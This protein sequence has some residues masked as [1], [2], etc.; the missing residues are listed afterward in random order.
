MMKKGFAQIPIADPFVLSYQGSYYAYG[1]GENGFR[2]YVSTDLL[3]WVASD[4]LCL[5][6]KDSYGDHGFWAPEVYY[7]E[8]YDLFYMFYTS[9]EHVCVATSQSPLGPFVQKVKAPIL[10]EKCIDSS[11]FFDDNGK[12]YLYF[13]RF[14]DGNVI[15]VAELNDDYLSIKKETLRQCI[16]AELDWE[17]HLGKVAEGPSV[18]KVGN[19]YH[20]LYS[21][22]DFR[23]KDYA[24]GY[25]SAKSPFGPWKKKEDAPLLHS[26]RITNI[27]LAGTGHGA[28]F[29]DELGNWYYIFHAH[30][31]LS[32]V[33]QR[34]SYIIPLLNV[35]NKGIEFGT[36]AYCPIVRNRP[37]RYLELSKALSDSIFRYYGNGQVGLFR[38]YY[39]GDTII[40]ASYLIGEDS[41]KNRKAAY[42]WP[43]SG[44]FSAL[45]SLY[46]VTENNRY[47]DEIKNIIIPGLLQYRDTTRQYPSY[48]SYLLS[49][50]ESDRYYDD[51]IW[52][53]IDLARLN[54]LS[55]D[56]KYYDEAKMIW[57]FLE[58]GMDD[59]LGGGIYW[60]EQK[61]TS[62]NACS[63]APAA[64]FAMK[65]YSIT[66]D[67]KYLDKA[68]QLY[69]W[70]LN[71]L[72]DPKDGLILDNV[73]LE[74]R[75]DRRKFAY[76][77]GQMIEASSLLYRATGEE[78]YLVEAQ[79]IAEGAYKHFFFEQDGKKYLKNGNIWF[80]AIMLRGFKELYNVDH[81]VTYIKAY[82]DTFRK[83][84]SQKKSS[85]CLFVDDAFVV[86]LEN[87]Q[88]KKWLL[89]QAA[90][91][92]MFASISDIY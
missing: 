45:V 90:M 81:N 75:V 54:E 41:Q 74:G 85:D 51:N 82:R 13:V 39:Q 47:L 50:G 2:P 27:Q 91:V 79:K 12:A 6:P 59:K 44:M 22:N 33:G 62:K 78:H 38:E 69:S 55:G 35:D 25:A 61:K 92:E 73:N 17:R 52:L 80:A 65:L 11:V 48:Q 30:Q 43:T 16:K 36:N 3:E 70:V 42:L 60:C 24:V 88:G 23:S 86:P 31:N 8:Q 28:P 26:S 89:T 18:I 46:S 20:M 37:S 63:N 57:D 19:K 84:L 5:S 1:T 40:S 66:N 76:N 9:E 87:E 71:T 32:E 53:G 64:V 49:A 10:E 77:S 15:W 7:I 14:T 21:A 67:E 58:S 56:T 4:S 29:C 72:Q 68:R 34:S 83:M